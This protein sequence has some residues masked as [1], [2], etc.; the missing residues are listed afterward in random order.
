M[1]ISRI[2]D[3]QPKLYHTGPMFAK[4]KLLKLEDIAKHHTIAV[5]HNVINL[6]ASSVS[7]LFSPHLSIGI[8]SRTIQHFSELFSTKSYRLHTIAWIGPR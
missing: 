4:L 6:T 8:E 2:I 5:M 1:K 3:D 7:L